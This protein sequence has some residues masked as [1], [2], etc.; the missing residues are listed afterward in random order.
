MRGF[1][2]SDVECYRIECF[3]E[4][5]HANDYLFHIIENGKD[6]VVNIDDD[7]FVVDWGA[8]IELI[9][10]MSEKGYEYSGMCDGGI[11][12]HRRHSWVVVNPFF[13]VFSAKAIRN[14]MKGFSKEI[15]DSFSYQPWME[16]YRPPFVTK[17]VNHDSAEPFTGLFYWLMTNSKGLY[18]DADTHTDN[19]STILKNHAGRTLLY[20][21]WMAREYNYDAT[22]HERIDNLYA[23]ARQVAKPF[24]L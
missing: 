18:L 13:T 16:E 19:F 17:N 1:L 9:Q 20:H 4:W 22:E 8:I 2:P 24:I 7:A 15:I 10:Y 23:T 5:W 14:R 12:P 6:W 11:C 3:R 21:S